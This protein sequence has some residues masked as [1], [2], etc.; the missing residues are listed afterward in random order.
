MNWWNETIARLMFLDVVLFLPLM[1]IVIY[2]LFRPTP[3]SHSGRHMPD[4]AVTL[5]L[6][7][8]KTEQKAGLIEPEHGKWERRD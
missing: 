3:P 8:G 4:A 5:A 2:K 7:V 6:H 1:A